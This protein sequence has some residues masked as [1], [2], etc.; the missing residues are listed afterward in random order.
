[1]KRILFLTIALMG[2][3][4]SLLA[5]SN[6]KCLLQHQGSVKI[7]DASAIETAIKA[8]VDGDTIFLTEGQFPGFTVNKKITVRGAGQSTYVTSDVSISISGSPT[9]TQTVLEGLN[10]NNWRITVTTSINGIKIKQCKAGA[11]YCEAKNSAFMLDRCCIGRNSDENIGIEYSNIIELTAVNS[12]IK[13]GYDYIDAGSFS[14]VNCNVML[15]NPYN[16]YGD[17]INSVVVIKGDTS[18]PILNGFTDTIRNSNFSYCL[19]NSSYYYYTN[20]Y[21]GHPSYYESNISLDNSSCTANNCYYT[22]G[23]DTKFYDI[24]TLENSDYI[25]NDGTIVG[26]YGGLTPYT[27]DLDVPKVTENTIV[28]DPISKTLNISLKVS[29]N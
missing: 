1:M 24:K 16:C 28:L 7:Y 18:N 12:M 5:A 14:F 17:F 2:I 21:Y 10:L 23:Y 26:L 9:L 3:S 6:A 27:L 25:G 29:A 11:L 8:S 4:M 13:I 15:S 20:N 22:T 19:I